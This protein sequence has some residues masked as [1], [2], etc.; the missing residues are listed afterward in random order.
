VGGLGTGL[1]RLIVPSLRRRRPWRVPIGS[2]SGCITGRHVP[3]R[4]PAWLAT[5]GRRDRHHR[6]PRPQCQPAHELV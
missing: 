5:P 2:T 6:Q 1:V 3:R 4:R